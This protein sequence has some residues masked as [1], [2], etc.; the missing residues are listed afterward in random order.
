M[1]GDTDPDVAAWLEW[2]A[3]QRRASALTLTA[4]A[5]ELAR[6]SELAAPTPLARLAPHDIRRFAGRLHAAGLGS[7]SIARAL[8]A[9][10]GFYRWMTHY[11]DLAANPVEHVRPPRAPTRLPRAL[12]PDQAA[13]LLERQPE[14]GLQLRD[15]AMFE[16]FYSSGLR[17]AELVSLDVGH[18]IDRLDATVTVLGKRGKT[19]SVPVGR[20]ALAALDAWLVERPG[21]A[22]PDESALFV[23]RTGTR[24]SSG[25]VR[26]R[27]DLWARR[28]ALGVHVHP[29]MLRHSFASHVLQ[30]SGDL[31]A[32]QELL[33]HASIRS[34]QVYTHLDFQHLA[35]V[36][37]AAHPRARRK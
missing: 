7:R 36:Y 20:A 26:S 2:L 11:R 1:T 19:R 34:T 27:L 21:F 30:S 15:R 32:V 4:Y 35:K 22:R 25:A 23:T 18:G 8:S 3:S 14:D 6:L 16:L 24:M 31:R 17:L 37:D 12:S 33:G 9:W 29:H 28:C 5:R 10:R 13:A